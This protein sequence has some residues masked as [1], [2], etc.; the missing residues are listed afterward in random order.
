MVSVCLPSDALLQHL[1]SYLGFSYLGRGYLLHGCP[2]K[3]SCCSLP[4]MRGISCHSPF[5]PSMWDGFSRPSCART[6][7]TPWTW[8]CSFRLPPLALGVGLLLPAATPG[9]GHQPWPRSRGSS[10]PRLV[11]QPLPPQ[12][13][14]NI[15]VLL[16]SVSSCQLHVVNYCLNNLLRI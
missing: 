9:L 8:G 2:A 13:L 14:S 11:C 10:R 1:P 7:T 6:A 12:W 15:L 3:H 5:W 4:W 16:L